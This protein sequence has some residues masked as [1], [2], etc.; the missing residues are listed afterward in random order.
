M[1]CIRVWTARTDSKVANHTRLCV[2]EIDVS[3]WYLL[4]ISEKKTHKNKET[5]FME[6][7][8]VV[9]LLPTQSKLKGDIKSVIELLYVV[10]FI[11][12]CRVVI[13]F[14]DD[15]QWNSVYYLC[16]HSHEND[17]TIVCDTWKWHYICIFDQFFWNHLKWN[18]NKHVLFTIV[19]D[20]QPVCNILLKPLKRKWHVS[21]AK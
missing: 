6:E 18:G 20:N 1:F 14:L 8:Y 19:T 2:I 5:K 11:W 17:E 10:I 9:T 15:N 13:Y 16:F 12:F 4:L 7:V 21:I 3:I